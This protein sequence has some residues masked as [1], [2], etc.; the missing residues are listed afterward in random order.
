MQRFPIDR[1]YADLLGHVGLSVNEVL[2]KARLSEDLFS[3]KTPSLSDEEYFRFMEAIGDL[4]TDENLPIK[5]AAG[6]HIETFSPP[7][8][9]AYCSRDGITCFRRLAHYKALIG[10]IVFLITESEEKV[11]IEI[12]AKNENLELPELLIGVELIFL[13]HLI[14]NATKE[15]IHPLNITVRHQL[16]N[17]IY[18]AFFG[19]APEVGTRNKIV[20][21]SRD[22]QLPF[23]SRNDTMWE[24]FEPELNRRLSEM[25]MDD[26]FSARV[27]S[28]L[29]E[30]LPAGE[31]GIDAVA[32]KLGYSKRTLQRKLNEDNT[33]F[34][35]QLNHTREL[36]AKHYIKNTNMSSEDIAYLLGYQDINSFFRAFLLW[37]GMSISDYKKGYTS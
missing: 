6:E 2:K 34:Q 3:R 7:I 29:I 1:K 18:K 24:Y 14:R 4:S 19:I 16:L 15:D 36:L 33:N 17:P 27:R 30:L 5:L 37:T 10:G 22:A 28:A 31:C 13:V 12:T 26:T 20:F 35:K 9:A 25:E 11:F 8:F 32:L 23:I 21:S